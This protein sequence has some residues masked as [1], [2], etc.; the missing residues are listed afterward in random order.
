MLL[1]RRLAHQGGALAGAG[2]SMLLAVSAW[3]GVP[4]ALKVSTTR[5][6]IAVGAQPAAASS[7]VSAKVVAL[8]EGVL[9]AML[10]TKL[11]MVSLVLLATVLAGGWLLSRG[12]EGAPGP[13]AP[14][15]AAGVQDKAKSDKDQLSEKD[16][17]KGT[18]AAVTGERLEVS[19]DGETLKKWVIVF[20][21]E[22]FTRG[23]G[24]DRVEG[25]FK[26]DAD[27]KPKQIDMVYGGHDWLGIYELK[28][29]TFKLVFRLNERPTEFSSKNAVLVVCEKK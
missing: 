29:D 14:V 23:E 25:T 27:K 16:R 17:L 13:A 10:L 24:A 28:G 3:A 6:A 2:L 4:H 7:V 26:I 22:K 11:K 5:A 8:M 20:D 18:W 15:L 19:F 12:A 9:K 1:A 21:D